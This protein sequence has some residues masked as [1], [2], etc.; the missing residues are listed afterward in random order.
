MWQCDRHAH[1][2]IMATTAMLIKASITTPQYIRSSACV[3]YK[4]LDIIMA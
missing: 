3:N 2:H 1:Y 4:V